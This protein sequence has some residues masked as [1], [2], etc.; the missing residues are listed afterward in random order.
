MSMTF[1][2]C[3]RK[4][5]QGRELMVQSKGIVTKYFSSYH[6]KRVKNKM[7]KKKN[8]VLKIVELNTLLR[9]GGSVSKKIVAIVEVFIL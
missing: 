3:G 1:F 9:N 5:C 6:S 8:N 4:M 7:Q 2:L